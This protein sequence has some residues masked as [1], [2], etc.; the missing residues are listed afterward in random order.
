M[1]T[2]VTDFKALVFYFIIMICLFVC[3]VAHY[4][5]PPASPKTVESNS[6]SR[7]S[8]TQGIVPAMK[9]SLLSFR[10]V[11]PYYTR[12]VKFQARLRTV[13]MIA[14]H[15]L[16]PPNEV[17]TQPTTSTMQ[18][19]SL[20]TAPLFSAASIMTSTS[21][22]TDCNQIPI[23]E[24]HGYATVAYNHHLSVSSNANAIEDCSTL[25][26]LCPPLFPTRK[27]EL[28]ASNSLSRIAAAKSKNERNSS[29]SFHRKALAKTKKQHNASNLRYR[30]ADAQRKENCCASDSLYGTAFAN[31]KKVGNV[32]PVSKHCTRRSVSVKISELDKAVTKFR[33][34]ICEGPTFVC[35][36]CH[37]FLYRQSLTTFSKSKFSNISRDVIENI[38]ANVPRPPFCEPMLICSTC[39]YHLLRNRIPP[40]AAINGLLLDDVPPE[41]KEL[42]ELESILISQR[43]FFMKL[44]SLSRGKQLGICGAMVNVP[45]N[46]KACVD[47][48]PRPLNEAGLV[49][50]KLKRKVSY[51]GY[52]WHQFIRPHIIRSALKL[53][54]H[55]NPLY[56][57]VTLNE[58]WTQ[59]SRQLDPETWNALSGETDYQASQV[60]LTEDADSDDDFVQDDTL[61]EKL[62][63]VQ[64]SSCLQP[65]VPQHALGNELFIVAPGEGQIPL[66]AML[67]HNSELLAFPK[68]FPYGRGAFKD[69]RSIPLSLKKYSN[70]RILNYDKRFSCDVNYLFY[71]QFLTEQKQIR[72]NISVA[73]R[74][75]TGSITAADLLS[76]SGIRNFLTHD[77]AF[78]FLKNVRGTPPFWSLKIKE[79]IAMVKQLGSPHFFLTLSAADMQW[80]ELLRILSQQKGCTLTDEEI[81]G[82]SYENKCQLLREDPVL[83]ARQFEYRLRKFFSTVLMIPCGPLGQIE[84]Y[85]YRIEF[86]LRGS[87]HAHCLIWLQNGPDVDTAST[88]EL[89]EF[90]GNYISVSIPDDDSLLQTL[91]PRLQKHTH[92][93]ACKNKKNDKCRFRFPRPPSDLTI[94]ASPPNYSSASEESPQ[95]LL[96]RKEKVLSPVFRAMNEPSDAFINGVPLTQLLCDL[97]IPYESYHC[98][99]SMGIKGRSYIVQRKLTEVSINNYNPTILRAWQANMDI[100]PVLDTYA[101][102]VYICSYVTKDERAMSELLRATKKEFANADIKIQMKKIGSTFLSNREVSAQEAAYRLLSL[103]MTNCNVKRVFIP[104]NLPQDRTR[105]MKSHHLLEQLDPDS[106]DVFLH[107]LPERYAARPHSLDDMCLAVFAS[108]YDVAYNRSEIED[109]VLPSDEV[110]HPKKCIKIKLQNKLGVMVKRSR[111]AVIRYHRFSQ[112]KQPEM[113][114]HSLLMLFFPWR[115][116]VEDLL[117][118]YSSFSESFD[119]RKNIIHVNKGEF[120]H[121]SDKVEEAVTNIIDEG[122]FT[123]SL[124][125]NLAAEV[126][127]EQ[128][129]SALE[130]ASADDSF[131][132]Y[133]PPDFNG[134]V[135]VSS[136]VPSTLNASCSPT[137]KLVENYV[138]SDMVTSLNVE[139]R[140]LFQAILDW[141]CATATQA[142]VSPFQI[143]CSGG[144]GVGKT[145][146]IKTIMQMMHRI[147]IKPGD[148][149]AATIVLLCAPTGTAAYQIGGIT[150]HSAFHLPLGQANIHANLSSEKLNTL[151]N[152]YSKLKCLIVDEISMVGATMLASIHQRLQ[153]ITGLPTEIP[154]GGVSILAVGDLQ[155]LPPVCD[156]PIYAMSSDP[157]YGFADLFNSNFSLFNLTEIMRQKNDRKFAEL[158]SRIRLGQTTADD[159]SLL[160]SRVVT[161]HDI[162]DDHCLHLFSSNREVDA[163]NDRLLNSLCAPLKVFHAIDKLP[164]KC[165]GFQ[166]PTDDRHTGGL[167]SQLSLKLE[168]RVMLIRNVDVEHGLVNGAQGQV[169]GFFEQSDNSHP[170]FILV[171]FDDPHLRS[172]A[173]IAYPNF[174]ESIPIEQFEARFPISPKRG[175]KLVEAT[176]L[177]YP[178][179]ISFASTIHK[180]Q[181]QTLDRVIVSMTGRFGPGQAYVALSRCRT[182]LGLRILDFNPQNIKTNAKSLEALKNLNMLLPLFSSI[183]RDHVDFALQITSINCRSWNCH[184]KDISFDTDIGHSDV[185][186]FTETWLPANARVDILHKTAV[187]CNFKDNVNRGGVMILLNQTLHFEKLQDFSMQLLQILPVL[188]HCPEHFTI[189]QIVI[190]AVYRS[191]QLPLSLFSKLLS[192]RLLPLVNRWQNVCPVV[193]IG[194]FNVDLLDKH[195]FIL[196][197]SLKQFVSSPTCIT[198]SLLDHV[199]W[200]GSSTDIY[201]RVTGCYWSDHFFVH[202]RLGPG[203]SLQR[204]WPIL[205]V[206]IDGVDRVAQSNRLH[207]TVRAKEIALMPSENSLRISS[208]HSAVQHPIDK[209]PQ[210]ITDQSTIDRLHHNTITEKNQPII[211][212]NDIAKRF[213]HVMNDQ[214][215][216][217]LPISINELLQQ[218]ELRKIPVRPDGHCLLYSWEIAT[219]TSVEHLKQM[220]IFEHSADPRYENAGVSAAE[221]HM[222][223]AS[224]TF[225]LESIDAVLDMLSNAFGATVYILDR[226]DDQTTNAWKISPRSVARANPIFLLKTAN[227]YDA[228]VCSQP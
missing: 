42:T 149:P 44:M 73:F 56:S 213:D 150:L 175:S 218:L 15:Y 157:Y 115:D 188:V 147:L 207:R 106:T 103:P 114:Y 187:T 167:Q 98:A 226:N 141:S 180:C 38:L 83:A 135:D 144:A 87:P 28:Y 227:H 176:R 128:L 185:A 77:Q 25:N 6:M 26:T 156:S 30:L 47:S 199:Y 7:R 186:V 166:L 189:Q 206:P 200:S 169:K 154:F 67:D 24:Q 5:V 211:T 16:P 80:P 39:K 97:N 71:A 84:T 221:L 116:E 212:Y 81:A 117:G 219:G 95:I 11:S 228:L 59:E 31:R 111:R 62:S 57:G 192:E 172:W 193:V 151:R 112:E 96:D 21:K 12:N 160:Q 120:E 85:F 142:D 65:S 2:N 3:P 222:Y 133:C 215:L 140:I 17:H 124:W 127:H 173:S 174:G 20:Y 75:L 35:I 191:P 132:I 100:Q 137:A 53:L 19:L 45:S 18:D 46:V 182:L 1:I 29:R 225:D 153:A 159:L 110:H 101:C 209:Q 164:E 10:Y 88:N 27:T 55:I 69:Q 131:A 197:I 161:P 60:E 113:H 196:P 93:V 126:Q 76:S 78:Q 119:S 179:K 190:I 148:D 43:I 194:D 37:R 181:G 70:Q 155:Q 183:S 50:L 195:H 68:K 66:D 134:L 118:G 36:C 105:M 224:N 54:I 203:S 121:F 220:I 32:L 92:S 152:K 163:H 58:S 217:A 223:I 143:F 136:M 171:L 201:C 146:L 130:G 108:E 109:N 74:K 90:F 79:L 122:G 177:Q 49:P 216:V 89:A 86:Q 52:V 208:S 102:L 202:T 184:K 8:S 129:Q 40:Q 99:L 204:N 51:K 165:P 178:L 205:H 139:Q 63:G 158:L 123:E 107:G 82:L 170:P 61:D 104:T 214:I 48:L 145:H 22:L 64:H 13:P 4:Y 198:G 138:F 91:V 33:L 34:A 162:A 9:S 14:Q 41:I 210:I 72:D 23:I 168:C 94:V 125:D